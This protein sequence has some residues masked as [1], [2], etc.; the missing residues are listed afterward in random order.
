MK[1]RDA[2]STTDRRVSRR[3][4]HRAFTLM[5]MLVVFPLLSI[6]LIIG[7]KLFISNT[8][9][10]KQS[11][12]A[13]ERLTRTDSAVHHLRLDTWHSVVVTMGPN[14]LVLQQAEAKI[15]WQILPGGALQR[16]VNDREEASKHFADIKASIFKKHSLAVLIVINDERYMCPF[17]SQAHGT[18]KKSSQ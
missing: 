15:T 1:N 14:R 18:L 6:F 7:S 3:A 13:Q 17:S 16:T 5:H 11:A 10:L 4:R 12:V 9:L 8:Q 2:S